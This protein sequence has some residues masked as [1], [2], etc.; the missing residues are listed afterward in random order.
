MFYSALFQ[1]LRNK[2][3]ESRTRK[4]GVVVERGEDI[5][6]YII[7]NYKQIKL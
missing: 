7:V 2:Q 3:E 4:E 1:K 5:N 6:V